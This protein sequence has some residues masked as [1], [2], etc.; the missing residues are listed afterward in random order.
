HAERNNYERVPFQQLIMA[1]YGVQRDQIKGPGWATS[2]DFSEAARFDISAKVPRGATREQ[3]A[4]MLQNLLAERFHMSLHHE[5]AQVPG[6]AVVIA[7][8]G[9]KLKESRG[10]VDESERTKLGVGGQ[11]RRETEKDG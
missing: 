1:G 7:K 6:Y 8:G 11:F 5:T 4:T 9:S 3:A 2:E 10:P